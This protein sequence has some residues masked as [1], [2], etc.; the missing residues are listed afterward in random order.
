MQSGCSNVAADTPEK[1]KRYFAPTDAHA[2]DQHNDSCFPH[3]FRPNEFRIA[4][5]LPVVKTSV[6]DRLRLAIQAELRYI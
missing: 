5:D 1:E 2:T 4:C 6:G 3:I